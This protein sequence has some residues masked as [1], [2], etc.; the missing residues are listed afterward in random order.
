LTSINKFRFLNNNTLK[1]LACISML[2]DHI[3]IILF[4]KIKILR[5]IGRLAFPIFAF[6]ISEGAKHTKNKAKYF[7]TI[8]VLGCIFQ[9]IYIFVMR[10]FTL[11]I[12]LTFAVS[13]LLIY[14]L[15]EYKKMMF[16]K[17]STTENKI[18]ATFLFI[19]IFLVFFIL[20]EYFVFDYGVLGTLIPVFASVFTPHE[21]KKSNT[22]DNKYIVIFY[23]N[24]LT[25]SIGLLILSIYSKGIQYYS[26]LSI[27]PLLLYSGKRGKT[28]LKYFFYAFYPFHLVV[29]FLIKILFF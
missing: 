24:M 25:F 8:L 3:G 22:S 5:I 28:N 10:T 1:I 2:I 29:I 21:I 16:N 14:T 17:K 11:N 15:Q 6:M 27:I 4:P 7:L 20:N 23:L 18:Q 26:L 9:F 19:V 13:I 12:F